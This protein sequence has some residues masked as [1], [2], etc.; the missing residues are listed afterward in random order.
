MNHNHQNPV[1]PISFLKPVP[2]GL[3]DT[4]HGLHVPA[5]VATYPRI[6]QCDPGHALALIES[7]AADVEVA[8]EVEI[9]IELK[10][11]LDASLLNI[12][13]LERRIKDARKAFNE[14]DEA[15]LLE[16]LNLLLPSEE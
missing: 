10:E 11:Q 5:Y 15:L 9:D 7:I 3:L 16:I 8:H 13:M 12:E 2:A 1:D 14:N 4:R 6:L